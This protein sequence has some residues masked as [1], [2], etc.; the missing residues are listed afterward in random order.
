MN[1]Q[2]AS[3]EHTYKKYVNETKKKNEE[4]KNLFFI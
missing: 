1:N 2:E 4:K 3:L